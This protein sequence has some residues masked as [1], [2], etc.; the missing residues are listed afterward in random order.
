[1]S[2]SSAAIHRRLSERHVRR[3]YWHSSTT[4]NNIVAQVR[5]RAV[6]GVNVDTKESTGLQHIGSVVGEDAL[7]SFMAR[8]RAG[9]AA[10]TT[11][12]LTL[13]RQP[14]PTRAVS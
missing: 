13:T 2:R 4:V 7:T 11:Y 12:Q 14:Q 8:L 10:L 5:Q 3:G 6:D 9:L 1:V